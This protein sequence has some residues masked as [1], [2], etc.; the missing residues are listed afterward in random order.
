VGMVL[1]AKWV[2]AARGPA[3]PPAGTG[4]LASPAKA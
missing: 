1:G 4:E 2:D 3:L